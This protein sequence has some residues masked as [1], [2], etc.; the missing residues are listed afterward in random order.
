[1]DIVT[2]ILFLLGLVF[3]VIGAE[4][5]VKGASYLAS[6]VGVSQLVIGLTVVS[7]GTS[8]PEMAVSINAAL[9]QEA[10]IA[11]GN[12]VGSNIFNVLFILGICALIVPLV[13]NIQLIRVD[14]PLMVAT[15]GLLWV[16]ALDGVLSRV[17]GVILFAGIIGY[18]AATVIV[19]RRTQRRETASAAASATAAATAPAP[20]SGSLPVSVIQIIAG[21][22]LLILGA[23]W[24]VDGAV[25][26]ATA[27][28]I[29]PM[30]IGLTIVAAGT[31]LPEVAT[32]VM[33]AIRGQ[34]DIAVGNVVGSNIFNILGILGLTAIIA[35]SGVPVNPAMLAMDIPFMVAVAVG[36]LPIFF[37]GHVINR[38]EGALFLIYYVAYTVYLLLAANSHDALSTYGTVLFA[39]VTPMVAVT[40]IVHVSRVLRSKRPKIASQTGHPRNP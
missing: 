28:G 3:L 39:W 20:A 34:R 10:D 17:D 1:M 33:A 35:P 37:T 23:K 11:M 40:L 12:V 26:M 4:A 7:F 15:S 19:G 30:V 22:A 18:T 24:L 38:W 32:S 29:S 9:S 21:L 27:M 25:A 36:C 2:L 6:A 16:L 31:S 5:L 14:V 13:V 8:A